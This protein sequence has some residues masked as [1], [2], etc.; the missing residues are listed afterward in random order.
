M[1]AI[2]EVI[3]V[4]ATSAMFAGDEHR[5]NSIM[6]DDCTRIPDVLKY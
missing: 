1:A 3:R 4:S 2:G 6:M 5:E